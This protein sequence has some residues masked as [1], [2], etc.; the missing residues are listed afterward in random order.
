MDKFAKIADAEAGQDDEID[1]QDDSTPGIPICDSHRS[2][3]SDW[4]F[5]E[6]LFLQ[7]L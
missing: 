4:I 3:L 7:P 2:S 6:V 5:L 1:L